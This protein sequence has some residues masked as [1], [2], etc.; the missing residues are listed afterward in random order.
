MAEAVLP[1]SNYMQGACERPCSSLAARLV[2]EKI[3]QTGN[4]CRGATALR[5]E[6][7]RIAT[8]SEV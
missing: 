3:L 4:R 1:G 2:D 6:R 8:P 7:R 5:N